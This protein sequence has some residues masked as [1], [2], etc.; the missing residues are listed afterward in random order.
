M[1]NVQVTKDTFYAALQT[2]I[3]AGNPARTAVIRG[4]I[5]PGVLVQENELPAA[6]VDGISPAEAFC[7]RWTSLRVDAQNPGPLIALG[8]EI[9]YASDGTAGAAGMDR[10]RALAAMDAELATALTLAP[11]NAAA[12]T[13]AEIAGGGSTA[14]IP[15]GQNI[16]WSDPV[17]APIAIRGERL[18]RTATL[19]V[20]GYGN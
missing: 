19:E 11:M 12:E 16:F 9:R 14:A 10:G 20:F 8:C 15:T 2:R 4:L 3:A 5:R 18:E 13:Y 17:F 1:L 7:L 6:A